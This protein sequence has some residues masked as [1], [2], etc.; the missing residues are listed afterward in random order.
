MSRTI[1]RSSFD[2]KQNNTVRLE[3]A[4][5]GAP[6]PQAPNQGKLWTNWSISG[7]DQVFNDGDPFTQSYNPPS[8]F[9]PSRSNQGAG[10]PDYTGYTDIIETCFN[11]FSLVET[12]TY[13]I[14]GQYVFESPDNGSAFTDFYPPFAYWLTGSLGGPYEDDLYYGDLDD[15]D[16]WWDYL[17]CQ[18]PQVQKDA[19]AVNDSYLFY[20]D[21]EVSVDERLGGRMDFK[22]S[23]IYNGDV[24]TNHK[25]MGSETDQHQTTIIDITK[26]SSVAKENYIWYHL[27]V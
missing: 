17:Y 6:F 19:F 12:G 20:F 27:P 7:F 11:T 26:V 15:H 3:P 8:W 14:K 18:N 22:V 2:P 23:G 13:R 4:Y 10:A 24:L 25:T 16:G 1:Q 21:T 9:V 5:T